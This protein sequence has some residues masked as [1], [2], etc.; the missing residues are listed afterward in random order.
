MN[1]ALFSSN[2][3]EWETPLDLFKK[4]NNEFCFTLDPCASPENAKCIKYYTKEHNGGRIEYSDGWGGVE[5]FVNLEGG[6]K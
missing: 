2:S 4:L 5:F 6:E 3:C 1:H